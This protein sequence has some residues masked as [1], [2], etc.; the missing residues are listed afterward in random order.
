VPV[1]FELSDEPVEDG[2]RVRGE[3]AG[4]RIRGQQEAISW[5]DFECVAEPGR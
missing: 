4:G 2:H 5:V 1:G 3:Q